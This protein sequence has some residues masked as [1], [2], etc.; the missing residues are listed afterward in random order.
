MSNFDPSLPSSRLW[1]WLMMHGASTEVARDL[2]N[3]YASELA[4]RIRVAAAGRPPH[5]LSPQVSTAKAAADL[6]DPEIAGK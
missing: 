3:D 5:G 6:I 2:M 1:N 4:D